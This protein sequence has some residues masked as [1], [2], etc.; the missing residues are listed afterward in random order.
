MNF[1]KSLLLFSTP[2][3]KYVKIYGNRYTT[4]FLNNTEVQRNLLLLS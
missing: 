3:Y 2:T 1:I 4:Y